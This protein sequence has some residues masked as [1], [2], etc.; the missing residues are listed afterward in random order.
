MNFFFNEKKLVFFYENTI[1]LL[2]HHNI[3]M[4]VTS[5]ML[6]HNV[7]GT[8]F[9]EVLKIFETFHLSMMWYVRYLRI[10]R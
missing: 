5:L 10:Y 3:A 2:G 7:E 1:V 4:P 9:F 6:F 8:Y